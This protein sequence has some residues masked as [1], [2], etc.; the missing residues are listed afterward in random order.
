[1][2][3]VQK[4][5]LFTLSAQAEALSLHQKSPLFVDSESPQDPVL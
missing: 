5:I 3:K 2:Q 4:V 1:M